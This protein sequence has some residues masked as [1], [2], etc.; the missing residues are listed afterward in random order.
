M[1]LGFF[2]SF[3]RYMHTENTPCVLEIVQVSQQPPK[4]QYIV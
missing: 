4:P 2:D 3:S 1:V